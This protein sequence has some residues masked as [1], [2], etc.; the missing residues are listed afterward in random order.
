[1]KTLAFLLLLVGGLVLTFPGLYAWLTNLTGGTPIV[2]IVVG[3]V[4]V[5]L[6]LY[7]LFMPSR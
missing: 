5:I 2:Q 3:I 1:M 6:G 7:Y 4:A